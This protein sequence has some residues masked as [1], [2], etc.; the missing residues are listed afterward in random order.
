[1]HLK[2]TYRP[3]GQPHDPASLVPTPIIGTICW[4][5][6]AIPLII[7]YTTTLAVAAEAGG[8]RPACRRPNLGLAQF[9]MFQSCSPSSME[10]LYR[11]FEPF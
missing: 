3:L 2:T 7:N 4:S 8:P 6:A 1:M 9:A 10:L 5:L 11:A